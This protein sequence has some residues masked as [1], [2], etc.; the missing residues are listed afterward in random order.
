MG[1]PRLAALL[2]GKVDLLAKFF[3]I[4]VPTPGDTFTVNVGR[5]S[6][7]DDRDPFVSR[8]AA[9]LRAL[10]D[11]SDL[12]NSRFIHSTGQSGNVLSPLYH[13]YTQRWAQIGYLPMKMKR[14]DAEKGALGMLTL[15][16]QEEI[17]RR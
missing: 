5:Y 16:P 11:L 14:A 12:E 4:R 1:E 17:A 7:R 6:L 9:S 8:H 10:Y 15:A 3:D 2:V 13:N